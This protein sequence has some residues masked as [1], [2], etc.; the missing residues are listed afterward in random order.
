MYNTPGY[1]VICISISVELLYNY[2][3]IIFLCHVMWVSSWRR[4]DTKNK[5]KRQRKPRLWS[6]CTLKALFAC[7]VTVHVCRFETSYLTE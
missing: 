2:I 1:S 5:D 3:Y 4:Q 7:Y 6:D